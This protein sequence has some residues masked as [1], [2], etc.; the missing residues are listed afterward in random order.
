VRTIDN[1]SGCRLPKR[2]D[3]PDLECTFLFTGIQI[4]K[5]MHDK[6]PIAPIFYALSFDQKFP[7]F[8]K[9]E[10]PSSYWPRRRLH[11]DIST[12]K[13]DNSR[14]SK[15]H[16][17]FDLNSKAQQRWPDIKIYVAPI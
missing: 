3:S 4:G 11:I 2:F 15:F 17:F 10:L 7:T 5:H 8:I 6:H 13:N 14:L 9:I 16:C 1:N 12:F